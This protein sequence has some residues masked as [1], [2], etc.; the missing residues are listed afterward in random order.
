MPDASHQL[1]DD[2]DALKS[3][4]V[5]QAAQLENVV[6]R[7]EQLTT[8]NRRYK[9]QVLTLTEQLNLALARRYA[10]SSEKLSPDQIALFDEAELD[11]DVE[12]DSDASND[13]DE[14]TVAAHQRKRRGRRPIPDHL[15]RIDV[16]HELT[17]DKRRCEHDGQVLAE[18][19]EVVS[20]QLDIIPATIRVIRHIRK[21]YACDC[22]ECIK[23]APMP[24][25]PIPKSLASPGL[26]AHVTVSKYQDALPLYRQQAILTRI[27]IDLPRATL[28]NWMIRAGQLVQPVI[29]LLDDRLLSHDIVQMDE[30][31]VQV[32]KESGKRAQSK[33]Y[34][35][36]QRGGPPGHPIVRFHYDPG[37]GAG[38]AKRLLEG[39]K[40]FLQTDG[41]DGYN[42]VVAAN[43]LVHV[44]CWAH[45]RRRFS[46]AV[47]AQGRKRNRGKAHRGLTLIRKLYRVEKQTRKLDPE[48]RYEHRQRHA[49]PVLDELRSWLDKILPQVPP[50]SATGKALHYLHAEWDKLIRYLDDGRLEIDNN[51][52]ENAIRPFVLGRKNWLFSDSV[53]GVKASANLYSLIETAKANRLEPYAYLRYLF[54]ELPRADTVEAIE[55]LLPGNVDQDR[56]KVE[57]S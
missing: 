15:P 40:G 20:E 21:K 53:Q 25:Q 26:L 32:L 3:L 51:L 24:T 31:T 17:E 48:K 33:S 56:L 9:C 16:V 2:V 12:P 45:A 27:G 18:I 38:V 41:Y 39:F 30:T 34:L 50:T 36:L 14:V 5:E 42:A 19:G 10:A 49:R 22:G 1:P 37:R 11:S 46:D 44:G 52:A 8:E 47:K 13:A 4:L 29:N 23:T 6:A 54:T 43:G 57:Q 7:N 55:A 28:A 35:W